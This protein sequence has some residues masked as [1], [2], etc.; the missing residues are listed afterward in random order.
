MPEQL[1]GEINCVNNFRMSEEEMFHLS[2]LN[3][4]DTGLLMICSKHF[5]G[6]FVYCFYT[7]H[8]GTVCDAIA[9]HRD[10]NNIYYQKIKMK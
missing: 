7:C 1:R 10:L 4:K 2:N 5:R 8:T 9:T 3:D 6:C